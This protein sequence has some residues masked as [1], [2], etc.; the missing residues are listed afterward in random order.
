MIYTYKYIVVNNTPN[1]RI[2][3]GKGTL[4]ELEK[5][6]PIEILSVLQLFQNDEGPLELKINTDD[7]TYEINKI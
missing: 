7:E 1:G 2:K 4:E 6:I 5:V 3:A